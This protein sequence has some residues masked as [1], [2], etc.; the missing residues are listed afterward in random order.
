MRGGCLTALWRV[1]LAV[2]ALIVLAALLA[3][4]LAPGGPT[5]GPI[6][7]A[8]L[9]PG[10]GHPLGT[11]HLG[12]D[13][14]SRT[15]WGARNSLGAALLAGSIALTGALVVGSAAS[16]AG[17]WVDRVLMRGADVLLAF[18]SLLLALVIV[19]I[20]D[21][22]LWQ[23]AVAVGLALVP[24]YARLV[25]A[26]ILAVRERPFI[27]AARTLGGGPFWIWRRHILPNIAGEL[28]AFASVI[29]AWS[30]LNL[31]ALDFLGVSGGPSVPTWGRILGEGRPYLRDAPWI[32]LP[33]GLLL[34]LAV[35]AVM[36]V[37]DA[38]RRNLPGGERRQ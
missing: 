18:P 15:V 26:S 7:A 33:P 19:A 13:V 20:L 9:A 3:P 25:R 16:M 12:R 14:F 36:G 27:D 6:E 29:L 8:F 2:F 30:L 11:D 31:A 10:N 4:V 35:L 37:S 23:S 34:T 21:I 22:G 24:I 38:W 1:W 5:G 28:A 32:A 17:G